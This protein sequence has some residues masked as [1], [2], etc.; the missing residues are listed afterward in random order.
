MQ[1]SGDIM[2]IV[3]PCLPATALKMSRFEQHG[4][5]HLCIFQPVVD[6]H[7]STLESSGLNAMSIALLGS[8]SSKHWQSSCRLALAHMEHKGHG[9]GGHGMY[10]E[11]K[12]S[13]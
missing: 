12:V 2:I 6:E 1:T 4:A 3:E 10:L 8:S 5:Y 13:T 7:S 9:F 11:T